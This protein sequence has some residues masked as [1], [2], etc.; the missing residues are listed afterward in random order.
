[1]HY[2]QFNIADYRKDTAHL[3][4]LEHYIYRSLIDWYY[5]DE[6]P[7][8]SETQVVIRRLCLG[9]DMV[10][11]L[12]NVL[13]DFF[14]N[15][16]KG[17]IHKRIEVEIAEYHEMAQKNRNNGK[18]GGRPR[19]TQSVIS[20]NPKLTQINPNQELLTNNHINTLSESKDSDDY[21]RYPDFLSF[22]LA[23]PD[24]TGKGKALEAWIKRKPKINKVLNALSWQK[25]SKKWCDGYI[26]N[27]ATYINQRRYDDECLE[28]EQVLQ[29]EML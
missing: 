5:L 2:Y 27:P 8:P 13:S 23:Y 12:N 10:S 20:G 26:P 29:G 22:W 1:M 17:Y 18:L 14:Q 24:K 25:T 7:I 28:S 15:T 4:P 3:T 6:T 11:L 21:S 16:E 9:S 19:K